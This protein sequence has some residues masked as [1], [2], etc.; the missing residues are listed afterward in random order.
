[1]RRVFPAVLAC[2]LASAAHA[3]P[4]TTKASVQIRITDVLLPAGLPVTFTPVKDPQTGIPN[5]L[6]ALQQAAAKAKITLIIT[7]GP[8]V[9]TSDGVKGAL[10]TQTK[11]PYTVTDAAGKKQP[12][13]QTLDNGVSA[14]PRINA[15]GTIT[16]QLSVTETKETGPPV[17][18]DG[19]LTLTTNSFSTLR[20]FVSGQ[21]DNIGGIRTSGHPARI[22]FATVTVIPPAKK[23][24][25]P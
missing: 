2:C 23:A 24:S 18:P 7:P 3:A 14:L 20:T 10:N 8:T 22:F 11:Y 4:S 17:M 21:T 13:F 12:A 16:V 25:A 6:L 15:D 9:T 19:P 5:D 1:M